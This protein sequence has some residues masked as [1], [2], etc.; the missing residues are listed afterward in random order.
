MA[1]NCYAV[2]AMSVCVTSDQP[3]AGM[4]REVSEVGCLLVRSPVLSKAFSVRT[5]KREEFIPR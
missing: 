2:R 4:F 5:D 1:E 3:R